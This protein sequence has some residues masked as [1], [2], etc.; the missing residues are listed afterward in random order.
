MSLGCNVGCRSVGFTK[1]IAES[2]QTILRAGVMNKSQSIPNWP[3]QTRKRLSFDALI[4]Q[5]RTRAEQ[6][7]DS[8]KRT[9]V[10]SVADAMLS[11]VAMFSLKDPSLLAFQE[12]RNDENMRN[13]YRITQVPSDTQMRELLDPL[14]HDLLRPMFRDV[15]RELQ[16]GKALKPFVFHQ[17]CYLL[18]LDGTEYFSSKK[19]SCPSCMQ[20]KNKAGEI[21]YYH[22]MLGAVLVHPDCREVIPLAPEP[23][24]KQDGDNK[25][26][27]ERNAAKRLLPRI[28]KEHPH[29]KLIVVE[30]GLSSNAPHIRL[31]KRLGMHFLLGVKPDDHQ[32]LFE[33]VLKAF[34]EDRMTVLTWTDAS[35]PKVTCEISFVHDLPLNKEN[36]DL[37]INFLQYYEFGPDGEVRKRFSWVT[38]LTITSDDAGHL[39]RGGRARWKIENETFNT[40]KNQG[41]HF[42]HNY[43][44]GKINLSVILA[45]LM[46]L[47]FLVDQTQQLC[48]PLF[49]AVHK[50]LG[51]RRA[52]WDHV[53]SHFRHF[54]FD[55]MRHLYEVVLR[56]LAKELPAPTFASRWAR[57]P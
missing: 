28:R 37:R 41:Y 27:C 43:G 52:V 7:P 51:S 4:R 20:R 45:M 32:H 34:E 55:S 56:D 46:M 2:A 35:D 3:I 48:C 23:I 9:G 19:V 26:D 40:M 50:K 25:N 53:R 10:F 42:E 8:R 16:R 47:T 44:H 30:D 49:Q 11:A 31:L 21:T 22:Q 14:D 18:S 17:G 29:L 39:V 24:L 1:D 15:F 6:L 5:I 54:L 33:E 38:D 36:S 57:A 13:L 12:R